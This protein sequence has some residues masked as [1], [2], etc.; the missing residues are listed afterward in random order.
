MAWKQA[1]RKI[2]A[3]DQISEN[4]TIL[5]HHSKDE[6]YH[7]PVNPDIVVFPKS[8]IEISEIM[9]VAYKNKIP[10]VPFG[11]GSSLEGHSIPVNG[12]ISMDFQLM[13]NIIEIRQNDLLVKVQPGVTRKQLNKAL[14]KYGLFFPIDPGADATIG[15]MTSTNASGTTTVK[16]GAMKDV[17]RGLEV[18]LANGDIANIGGLAAKSSSGYNLT[19]LF[20]GSEGTLGVFSEIILKVFGIPEA[21]LACRAAFPS[22]EN[23]INAAN[24]MVTSGIPI[25]RVELVDSKCMKQVNFHNKTMYA[26]Q[27]TLFME[28]QGNEAGIKADV[29]FAQE[30]AEVEGCTRFEYE[31]DS[32]KKAQLW[33]ARHKL[34]YA[35][36][37][38]FPEKSNMSTD[39]CVPFSKLPDAITHAGILL[40]SYGLVGGVVGH[41]GDGNFHALMMINPND[42][43]ELEKA[44]TVNQKIVEFAIDCGGTSTGEHGIGL[45]K[46]DYLYKEHA[47]SIHLMKMIKDQFDPLGILNPGKMFK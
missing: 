4:P 7:L 27:P 40:E 32:K 18:V 46:I 19:P 10:V 34:V 5:E 28:F 23:A 36:K 2:L 20:V 29:A 25:A 11:A 6:S 38:S 16:Y 35:F 41:V 33:E 47:S 45:G 37:H 17:V 21:T 3:A 8:N 39:V 12:G 42:Q 43:V 22:V 24:A 13:N 31:T 44:H 14:K 15:G 9:K 26:E 1:L 30:L